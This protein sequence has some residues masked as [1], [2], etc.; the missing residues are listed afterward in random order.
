M[1]SFDE[2]F[3]LMLDGKQSIDDML[4]KVQAAW[5]EKF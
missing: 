5:N 4:K 1:R 3:Q 2:Q